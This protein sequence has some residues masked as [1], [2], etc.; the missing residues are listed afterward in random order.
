MCHSAALSQAAASDTPKEVQ[1]KREDMAPG[2]N[3]NQ[4]TPKLSSCELLDQNTQSSL[5]TPPP[6]CFKTWRHKGGAKPSLL[7]YLWVGVFPV[8]SPEYVTLTW[9]SILSASF[10]PS[11][12]PLSLSLARIKLPHHSAK[13]DR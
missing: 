7:F 5:A 6:R 12:F 4:H 8:A 3:H 2:S 9:T 13:W 11:F 10:S 1:T